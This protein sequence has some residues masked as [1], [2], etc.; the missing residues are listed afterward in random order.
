MLQRNETDM[1]KSLKNVKSTPPKEHLHKTP[2]MQTRLNTFRN[3]TLNM[4]GNISSNTCNN[5]K[6]ATPGTTTATPATITPTGTI[7][8]E[9]VVSGNISVCLCLFESF[10]PNADDCDGD[11]GF[12]RSRKLKRFGRLRGP[13]GF[14]GLKRGQRF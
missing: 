14:I 3:M 13:G 1:N 6:A 12:G 7:W 11:R 4:P 10:E 9:I 2:N 5:G 8:L